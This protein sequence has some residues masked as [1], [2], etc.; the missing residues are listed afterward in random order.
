DACVPESSGRAPIARVASHLAR[1][2][3]DR[4]DFNL[5]RLIVGAEGT[6]GTVTEAL[7]HVVPLPKERGVVCL[8][9]RTIDAA[10]DSVTKILECQPSAVELLDRNIVELSR[11]N[12]KYKKSLDFVEGAPE[13]LL[14]CEFSGDDAVQVSDGMQ[15]LDQKMRGQPGLE[16]SL[17]ARDAEQ[18]DQ[19]SN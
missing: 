7:L 13:A 16:K 12:L 6:L 10:L 19:I 9:F 3:P 4:R 15:L 1:K 11:T 17:P 18:R 5:A 14:I 8:Q 2:G